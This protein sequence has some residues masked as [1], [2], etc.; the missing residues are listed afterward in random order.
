MTLETMSFSITEEVL[1]EKAT[2]IEY[3]N[4]LKVIKFSVS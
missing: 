3:I 2:Q 1:L 4:T